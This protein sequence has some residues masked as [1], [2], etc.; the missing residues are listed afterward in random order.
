MMRW[1]NAVKMVAEIDPAAMAEIVKVAASVAALYLQ[2][3][4]FVQ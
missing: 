2:Q 4:K 3:W 1:L